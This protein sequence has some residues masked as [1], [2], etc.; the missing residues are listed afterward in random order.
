MRLPRN[1]VPPDKTIGNTPPLPPLPDQIPIAKLTSPCT[2]V[3]ITTNDVN[4]IGIHPFHQSD[5]SKLQRYIAG[6]DRNFT[7][8]DPG[9]ISQGKDSNTKARKDWTLR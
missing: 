5:A 7:A 1:I 4:D 6:E 9:N 2:W 3:E 8:P